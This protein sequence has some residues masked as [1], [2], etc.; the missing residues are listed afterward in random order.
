MT[1][2]I[3]KLTF[4]F[5]ISKIIWQRRLFDLTAS[6]DTQCNAHTYSVRIVVEND[7]VT[8]AD[9]EARQVV[10][11]ILGIKNIFIDHICCS[12][13]FRCV[14]PENKSK[15]IQQLTKKTC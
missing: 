11:G 12:S 15:E 1:H 3:S 9:V 14:P 5:I 13:C 8:I 4:L 2:F 7:Q 6:T 10:T